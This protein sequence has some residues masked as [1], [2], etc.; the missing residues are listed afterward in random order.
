MSIKTTSRPAA[1]KAAPAAKKAAAKPA[2]K[3]TTA[4]KA[5][6]AVEAPQA[7][8]PPAEKSLPAG[9]IRF[10]GR[11][12]AVAPPTAERMVVWKNTVDRLSVFNASMPKDEQMR[13]LGRAVKVIQSVMANVDDQDW[14]DDQLLDGTLTL[15]QA[16][17]IITLAVDEYPG[18]AKQQAP[19]NGPPPKARR[20]R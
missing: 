15:E 5:A 14:L 17:D 18:M 7:A 8:E 10:M 4:R 12:I 9:T 11:E 16:A 2:K 19:R 6:V 3:T 1:K 20:R 13:L